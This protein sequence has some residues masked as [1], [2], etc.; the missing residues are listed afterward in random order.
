MEN[1]AF[2]ELKV[3]LLNVL[4]NIVCK[5]S[6]EI[7]ARFTGH[8]NR[9]LVTWACEALARHKNLEALPYLESAKKR[10]GTGGK[11]EEAIKEISEL[12]R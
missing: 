11:I 4:G 12:N 10:L 9:Y 3:G 2:D 1:P 6:F 7:L 8:E 5:E